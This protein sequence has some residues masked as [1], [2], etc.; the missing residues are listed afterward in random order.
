[1]G[2]TSSKDAKLQYIHALTIHARLNAPFVMYRVKC[3]SLTHVTVC[4]ERNIT[5]FN[6]LRPVLI[7]S[8]TVLMFYYRTVGW[9]VVLRLNVPVNNFSVISGRSHRFLGN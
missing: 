6:V 2:N 7:R 3:L 4:N 9:L 8:Y 5:F 1:M